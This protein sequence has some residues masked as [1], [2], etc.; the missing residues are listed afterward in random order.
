[1]GNQYTRSIFAYELEAILKRRQKS[2]LDMTR[3]PLTFERKKVESL[4]ES[5]KNVKRLPALNYGEIMSIVI[6]LRLG[7]EERLR[8]RAALIALG[9]QRLLLD[10]LSPERVWQVAEE[11]R[12]AAYQWLLTVDGTKDDPFRRLRDRFIPAELLQGTEQVLDPLTDAL[13]AYDEGMAFS[14]LGHLQGGIQG[15][16]L[17]EQA[18]AYLTQAQKSLDLHPPSIQKTEEWAYWSEEVKKELASVEDE[19]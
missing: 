7:K 1:M 6:E 12:D 5:L 2:L 17:F 16:S 9:V 14:T 10:Y 13:E 19:L 18:R 8:L 11:V 4:V 3:V 15:Q